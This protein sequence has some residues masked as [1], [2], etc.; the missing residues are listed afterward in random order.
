MKTTEETTLPCCDVRIY[1]DLSLPMIM[2]Q[3]WFSDQ[4]SCFQLF[5]KELTA[6]EQA[7]LFGNRTVLNSVKSKYKRLWDNGTFRTV[8]TKDRGMHK[9]PDQLRHGWFSYWAACVSNESSDAGGLEALIGGLKT[10]E[11]AHDKFKPWFYRTRKVRNLNAADAARLLA[12]YGYLE[13]E[14]R[15]LLARGALRGAAILLNDEPPWKNRNRLEDEYQDPRKRHALEEAAA[16]YIDERPALA[17]FGRWRMEEG[18]NWFCN[19][20]HKEWY[21]E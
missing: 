13:P 2:L 11:T 16:T 21:P 19:V 1:D 4:H 8:S 20:V 14:E 9:L 7:Y 5:L 15:P 10:V 12:R 18:E 3:G 17:R 6:D